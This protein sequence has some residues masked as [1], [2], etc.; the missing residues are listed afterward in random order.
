LQMDGTP[1]PYEKPGWAN[2]PFVCRGGVA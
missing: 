2:P 1:M